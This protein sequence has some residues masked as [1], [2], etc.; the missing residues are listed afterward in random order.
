[1]IVTLTIPDY[2]FTITPNTPGR[3]PPD[4][5]EVEPLQLL[6]RFTTGS[7]YA[8]SFG[9]SQTTGDLSVCGVRN[10][11]FNDVKEYMDDPSRA[12]GAVGLECGFR[13]PGTYTGYLESTESAVDAFISDLSPAPDPIF[14]IHTIGRG[15]VTLESGC[16][17]VFFPDGVIDFGSN[18]RAGRC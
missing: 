17:V 13:E 12:A 7:G 18:W 1:V 11:F 10:D 8:I 3:N 15:T 5:V 2:S 6:F 14:D 9:D 16:E 4:D